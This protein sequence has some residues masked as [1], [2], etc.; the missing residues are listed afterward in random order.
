[1]AMS[2][3]LTPLILAYVVGF[4]LTFG[5]VLFGLVVLIDASRRKVSELRGAALVRSHVLG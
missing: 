3:H 5:G 2:D 1:M 4:A